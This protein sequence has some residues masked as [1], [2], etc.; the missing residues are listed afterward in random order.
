MCNVKQMRWIRFVSSLY[1]TRRQAR[2]AVKPFL[3]S[4]L[5]N[6]A[7]SRY[8]QTVRWSIVRRQSDPWTRSC[9]G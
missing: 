5:I 4:P 2:Y 7:G 9:E 8:H 3:F 1:N 6:S